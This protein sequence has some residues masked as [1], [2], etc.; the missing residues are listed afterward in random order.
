M[1]FSCMNNGKK[2]YSFHYSHE[3]WLALKK[4]KKLY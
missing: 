3:E 2:I 1:A 4:Y